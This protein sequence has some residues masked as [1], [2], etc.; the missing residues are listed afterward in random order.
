M[1]LSNQIMQQEF[2]PAIGHYA[3]YMNV[4]QRKYA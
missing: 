4:A 1:N 3:T 2:T